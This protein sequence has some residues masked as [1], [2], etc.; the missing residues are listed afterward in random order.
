MP[1]RA[2]DAATRGHQDPA[3]GWRSERLSVRTPCPNQR[4]PRP[5]GRG[6][7][8]LDAPEV[9]RS[10][11]QR[12]S[13]V[14]IDSASAADVIIGARLGISCDVVEQCRAGSAARTTIRKIHGDF[15]A[16]DQPA[17]TPL[18]YQVEKSE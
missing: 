16:R 4:S 2:R 3:W 15:I 7:R 11:V 17:P 6:K 5:S 18:I 8:A 10:C 9:Q 1:A 13:N 14:T 12:T